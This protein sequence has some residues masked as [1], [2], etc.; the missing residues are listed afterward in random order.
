MMKDHEQVV[1]AL[2][3]T[4]AKNKKPGRKP[5]LPDPEVLAPEVVTMQKE[6]DGVPLRSWKCVFEFLR[7]CKRG[8]VRLTD[9]VSRFV[10]G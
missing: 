9:V 8:V 1:S 7:Q 10:V 5:H 6:L 4:F 3:A 2:Y